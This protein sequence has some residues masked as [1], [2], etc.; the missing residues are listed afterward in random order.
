MEQAAVLVINSGSSSLKLGLFVPGNGGDERALMMLSANGVGRRDGTLDVKDGAGKELFAGP[1]VMKT[2]EDALRVGLEKMQ[3]L[4]LPGPAAV[5]H[6]VVHGGPKLLEHQAITP[7][8]L[9]TLK[10]AVHF[11]PLHIPAALKLIEAAEKVFPGVAQFACF[12]TAFHETMPVEA[13]RLPLPAA[14]WDEGVRR[15]GF[16]GL[17]YESIVH[18]LAGDVPER[19]I[20]AHLGSGCSVCALRKGKSV[21]TSMGLTP[22]GGVTMATRTGDLDPGVLLYL[23]RVKGMD[24]DGLERMLN[25]E[26]G[27]VGIGGCDG[28]VRE[29]EAAADAGDAEAGL[30]LEVFY[31]EIAKVI[32]GYG[33]V[34]GGVDRL[35]FTGGIGEH[36]ART[37][38]AVCGRVGVAGVAM[39]SEEDAQ[40]ARHCRGLMAG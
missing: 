14:L 1:A 15:Y 36:S 23:L 18:Q 30:A 17:S 21:D 16:H 38:D 25:H 27:L 12:D 26:C 4:G 33:T 11:A 35:V 22:T 29:L 28:D 3:G 31:R 32:A 10:D 6:R 20:V 40:I 7:Q 13:K 19:M 5:G 24:A 9:L 39:E 37:R 34:L 2:Q 8:V